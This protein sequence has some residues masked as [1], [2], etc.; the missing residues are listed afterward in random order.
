M[1]SVERTVW[2][3]K[4][5]ASMEARVDLPVPEAPARR[6]I[7]LFFDWIRSEA[8]MK[9]SIF[10]GLFFNLCSLKAS[11]KRRLNMNSVVVTEVS[12]SPS[13]FF[14]SS[15]SPYLVFIR[16]SVILVNTYSATYAAFIGLHPFMIWEVCW[17]Y[18]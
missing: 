10:L 16:R 9:S 11:S 5:W 12:F 13:T 6:T 15:P 18:S 1:L 3:P 4:R 14:F 17:I 8:I 2:M 7:T